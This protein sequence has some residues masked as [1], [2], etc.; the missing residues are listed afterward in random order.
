MQVK[1]LSN[2]VTSQVLNENLA[3]NFGYR[4]KLDQFND[5]QLED[6][7]NKLRTEVN[8][9][10]MNES[11][12][13]I[14]ENN[15]Y[16]KTRALLDI[17]NQAIFERENAKLPEE[18]QVKFN[19]TAI[20]SAI[21]ERGRQLSVPESWIKNA[22]NRIKLGESDR[23][24]LAAELAIRYDLNESQASWML[25]EGE[26]EKAENILA[27][28]DMISKITNWIED[29]AAMKADQLLELLD[30]IREHQGSQVANQFNEVVKPALES[31]YN[32]LETA[33]A[34]LSQGLAIVSGENYEQ[35]GDTSGI[36]APAAQPE[37]PAEPV[38]LPAEPETPEGR[39]KRESVEYH[40]RLNSLLKK[41]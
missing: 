26:E 15:Q 12:D 39:L 9:M 32:A 18:Q 22:I 1:D 35:M 4:L 25:L 3:K 24:E 36:G 27:S 29:T 38:N 13:S 40:N 33:R 31:I 17:V 6:V 41:K 19:E 2:P 30:S 21:E 16:Q 5:V 20:F 11:Y 28:K 34:S 23:D 37:L 7:R 14:I 8:Q 10:E